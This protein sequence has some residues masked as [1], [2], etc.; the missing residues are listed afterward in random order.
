MTPE[1]FNQWREIAKGSSYKNFVENV[2]GGQALLDHPAR[3]RI[4]RVG[5]AGTEH[6]ADLVHARILPQ[7]VNAPQR[8]AADQGVRR[9]TGVGSRL[10]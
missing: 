9:A 1:E 4:G 8:L 10:G 3:Q 2:E 5:R 6:H 7:T